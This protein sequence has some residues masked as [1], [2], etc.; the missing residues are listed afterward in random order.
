MDNKVLIPVLLDNWTYTFSTYKDFQ[1]LKIFSSCSSLIS[2]IFRNYIRYYLSNYDLVKK[3]MIDVFFI[4][5]LYKYR[6]PQDALILQKIVQRKDLHNIIYK[7]CSKRLNSDIY[8]WYL[9]SLSKIN[10]YNLLKSVFFL[11]DMD[12]SVLPTREVT[13]SLYLSTK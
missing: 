2:N 4:N 12:V 1:L 9:A 13:K 10:S 11:S 6:T 7:L 3:K 8:K 5:T